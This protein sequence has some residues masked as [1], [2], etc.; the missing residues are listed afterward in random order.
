V[1]NG[2]ANGSLLT[3]KAIGTIGLGAVLAL[4]LVY[5]LTTFTDS[6]LEMNREDVR[7]LAEGT[8]SIAEQIQEHTVLERARGDILTR[9]LL[10]QTGLI[11]E[12]CL[13]GAATAEDRVRCAKARNHVGEGGQ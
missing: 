4:G 2:E 9:A 5:W 11:E 12:L 6:L 1:A 8:E 7:R 10:Q 3:P 13:Q